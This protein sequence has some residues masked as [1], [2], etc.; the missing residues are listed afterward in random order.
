MFGL[1]KHICK[2]KSC[3][4]ITNDNINV[5]LMHTLVMN[6]ST[7]I[8]LSFLRKLIQMIMIF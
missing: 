4:S 3:P 1:K 2:E 5:G 8:F 6:E 7:D